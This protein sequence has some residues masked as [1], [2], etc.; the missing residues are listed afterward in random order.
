MLA[1]LILQSAAACCSAETTKSPTRFRRETC[2]MTRA[3]FF[4]DPKDHI[5]ARREGRRR[6]L[7]VIGF[8]HSHPHSLAVPSDT[9]R[10]EM[11]YPDH[12]C[13]ILGLTTDP[14]QVRAFQ[15]EDGSF[16]EASLRSH[17]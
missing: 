12:L 10:A 5:D 7:D 4:V 1:R 11:A 17:D 15:F 16:Q 13:V 2:P 3:A 14:E 9:D 8:Y 6:G